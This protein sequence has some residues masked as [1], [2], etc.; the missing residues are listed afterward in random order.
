MKDDRVYLDHIRAAIDDIEHYT[1]TGRDVFMNERM[2]QN[3]VIRK[4]ET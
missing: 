2:Q 4:L 3:A 1:T